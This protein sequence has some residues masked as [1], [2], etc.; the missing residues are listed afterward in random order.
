ML[1]TILV[2]MAA[3]L[4]LTT[5]AKYLDFGRGKLHRTDRMAGDEGDD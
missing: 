2:I 5:L 1:M 3:V 4:T